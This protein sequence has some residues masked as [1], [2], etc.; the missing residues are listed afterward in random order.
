M[1][2]FRASR[3]TYVAPCRVCI[4]SGQETLVFG[5]DGIHTLHAG[6]SGSAMI[7][8]T[9][10]NTR[11]NDILVEHGKS[12]PAAL[13]QNPAAVKYAYAQAAKHPFFQPAHKHTSMQTF[14]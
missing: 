13:Y 12:H 3:W 2:C 6:L 5:P 4:R 1:G 11:K 9:A 8:Q 7:Y 14:A 10:K